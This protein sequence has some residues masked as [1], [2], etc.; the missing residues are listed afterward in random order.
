MDLCSAGKKGCVYTMNPTNEMDIRS[1]FAPKSSSPPRPV[2]R[3]IE[4]VILSNLRGGKFHDVKFKR[5]QRKRFIREVAEE[6]IVIINELDVEPED[7]E[8]EEEEA[9][10]HLIKDWL[11][12]NYTSWK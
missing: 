3:W 11:G 6:F 5:N 4:A 12:D 1:F 10:R 9:M 8:L 7:R 2:S